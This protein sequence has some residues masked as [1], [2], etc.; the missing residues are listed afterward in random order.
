MCCCQ[1]WTLEISRG[2]H[3]LMGSPISGPRAVPSG[4]TSHT[5]GQGGSCCCQGL[6]LEVDRDSQ[7]LRGS[8][9]S[10]PGLGP[11]EEP[12][13][14]GLGKGGTAPKNGLWK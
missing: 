1:D 4:G 11:V 2:P 13:S 7:S 3:S 5:L 10:A 14:G 12:A 6:T 8:P 9:F